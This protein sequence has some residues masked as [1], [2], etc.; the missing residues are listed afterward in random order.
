MLGTAILCVPFIIL[1]DVLVSVIQVS[2]NVCACI[3]SGNRGVLHFV[4]L[5][6]C[7]TALCSYGLGDMLCTYSKSTK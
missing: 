7:H 6:D 1:L 2:G 5:P 4:S 3:N